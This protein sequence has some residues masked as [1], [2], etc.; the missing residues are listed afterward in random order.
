MKE[1]G[2]KANYIFVFFNIHYAIK[3]GTGINI[4]LGLKKAIILH[5]CIT[6]FSEVY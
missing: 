2:K 5:I 3:D 1:S 6:L 4:L